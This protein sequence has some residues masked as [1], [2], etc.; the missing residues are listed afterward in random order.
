MTQLYRLTNEYQNTISAIELML[1][2][3]EIDSASAAD[4]LEGLQ[5]EMQDKAINV[6]LHIKN[7]R[8]D[9]DQLKAEKSALDARIKSA[10]SGLDFYEG[11]LDNNL[12]KAGIDEIKTAQVVIKYKKLPAIVDVF[13]DVPAEYQRVIPEK[14]EPDKVAIKEAIKNGADTHT[15][16]QIIDGRTK[17]DIK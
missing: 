5:G 4:T 2:S 1:D 11:Y 14:R 6:A 13:G 7:L 17:L 16:A 9:V 15:F 10:E 3:G 8:S 12:R